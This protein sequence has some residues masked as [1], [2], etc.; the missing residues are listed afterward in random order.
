MVVNLKEVNSLQDWIKMRKK[1]IVLP[2]N[3][4]GLLLL[5]PLEASELL[6]GWV[7]SLCTGATTGGCCGTHQEEEDPWAC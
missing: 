2:L 1:E 4:N 5:Q 7:G 6:K 3:Y